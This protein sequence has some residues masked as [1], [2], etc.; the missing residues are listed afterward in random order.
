MDYNGWSLFDKVEL[1]C[2]QERGW[3][4]GKY[5]LLPTMQGYVV[6]PQNKKMRESAMNWATWRQTI[7][8]Q[9]GT[10][11]YETIQPIVYELDNSGFT[12][13]LLE[14]AQGSSQGGKLSFWNCSISKDGVTWKVGIGSELLLEL[15]KDSTF[16]NGV[17]QQKLFF[18]RRAGNV[19]MLHSESEAYKLAKADM[20]K[21]SA[22]K[23]AK[24]TSK[25]VQGHNY[26]TLTQDETYLT[27]V[28][29]WIEPIY[30]ERKSN[31][32]TYR[33]FVGYRRVK[34]PTV[35]HCCKAT[36][37]SKSCLSDYLSTETV[38]FELRDKFPGRMEGSKL[39]NIDMTDNE[40]ESLF[41]SRART[42]IERRHKDALKYKSQGLS[43]NNWPE[44]DLGLSPIRDNWETPEDI[45][46]M[47]LEMGL[48]YEE[49]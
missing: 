48:R 45:K 33:A 35:V 4:D 13:S 5:Q 37:D 36:D 43:Y 34:N 17:C 20:V 19:G 12:L 8:Q 14:A 39:I 16:V 40:I 41:L 38:W 9:D 3:K 49:E 28:Y 10:Y 21:K 42:R 25:W 11:A 27:P 44:S 6:D 18:A 46:Q 23:S 7:P 29:K 47:I 22:V 30:E 31:Y 26:I 24:K 1:I 2:R 32:H 15:L